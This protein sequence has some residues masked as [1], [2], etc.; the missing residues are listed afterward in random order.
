MTTIRIH[1]WRACGALVFTCLISCSAET[2]TELPAS[3][4][5]VRGPVL[6][7][8]SGGGRDSGALVRVAPSA[9]AEDACG[10][11]RASVSPS[12]RVLRQT[13]QGRRVSVALEAISIGDTVE[14]YV[15]G[16]VT[17][18]CEAD[19]EASKIVVVWS[20]AR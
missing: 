7:V 18:R 16:S 5:F 6:E 1:F 9:V 15:A 8:S 3:A 14:V 19:G 11:I 13:A 12:T 20:A 2:P 4:P 10:G 17:D